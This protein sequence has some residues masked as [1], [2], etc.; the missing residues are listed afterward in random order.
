MKFLSVRESAVRDSVFKKYPELFELLDKKISVL[1]FAGGP[2]SNGRNSVFNIFSKVY[3]KNFR[4]GDFQIVAFCTG[5]VEELKKSLSRLSDYKSDKWLCLDF[6][7]EDSR[8]LFKSIYDTDS[9]DIDNSS[10]YLFLLDK[11]LNLRGRKYENRADVDP[12]Y[13][14]QSVGDLNNLKD[15]I[16]I[17]L[18][19]Y[20]LKD[21]ASKSLRR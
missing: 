9:I 10:M 17:L 13:N 3:K 11:G 12:I 19:E 5:G 18:K 1:Y 8:D 4:A 14:S 20:V 15:D 7:P 2:D 6:S 16:T 21:K